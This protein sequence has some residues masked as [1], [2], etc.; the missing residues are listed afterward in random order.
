MLPQRLKPDHFKP[1]ERLRSTA[2]RDWVRGHFC[3]VPGCQLMPIEVAHVSRAHSGGMG[4]KSSDAMT[5]SL[6]AEHHAESH[7]GDKTFERK[8]GVN[9]TALAKEFYQRSPHKGK[10]DDPWRFQ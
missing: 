1:K 8:H 9:L 3:S 2:H 6:C 7:R 5:I 10:L 4:M